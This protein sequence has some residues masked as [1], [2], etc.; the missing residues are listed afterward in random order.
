MADAKFDVHFWNSSDAAKPVD[1]EVNDHVSGVAVLRFTIS[2][3]DLMAALGGMNQTG[4]TGWIAPAERLGHVGKVMQLATRSLDADALSGVRGRDGERLA[5]IL[6]AAEA[7]LAARDELGMWDE[8]Q[9]DDTNRGP[10]YTV[11]RYVTEEE[12]QQ[13]LPEGV[14]NAHRITV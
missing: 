2:K 8:V 10:Q 12:A 9:P 13:P 1:V 7:D 11:R 4:I 6:A 14:R 5:A 3:A